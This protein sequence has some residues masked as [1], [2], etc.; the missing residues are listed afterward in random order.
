MSEEVFNFE[1][2]ENITSLENKIGYTFKDGELL[3]RALTHSSFSNESGKKNQHLLCNERLEF[4]GDSVLSLVTTEYIF[5]EYSDKPEGD[6][7]RIRAEVV[8]ERALSKYAAMIGLGE[9]LYL[10]NGE[11]SNHGRENASITADAFEALLA[12]IFLDGGFASVKTFLLPFLTDE[13]KEVLRSGS[14][15]DAKTLLQ[16]FIQQNEGDFLKY[17]TVSE[18]GPPHNKTFE[19]VATL[20]SNIIGRGVGQSKKEAE[21]KAAHSALLLFGVIKTPEADVSEDKNT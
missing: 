5:S 15:I 1:K 14:Y 6:L 2:D 17:D 19:V 9:H 18:S 3:T 12:A 10:G 16:Q 11:E 21:Q 20:N 7:T 13:I 8:C 4:L